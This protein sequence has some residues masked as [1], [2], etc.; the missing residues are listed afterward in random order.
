MQTH[1]EHQPASFDFCVQLRREGMPIEDAAQR[2][3][4][5]QSPLLKVATLSIPKQKFRTAARDALA[6]TLVFSPGHAR[7]AHAALGGLNRARIKIY[8]ALSKFRHTRDK[9]V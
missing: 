8:R 9:A 4:E 2:W 1:L 3:D 6:E 7:A 5:R